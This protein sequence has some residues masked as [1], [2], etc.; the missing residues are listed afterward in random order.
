MVDMDMMREP[1]TP[2][3]FFKLGLMCWSGHGHALDRVAAHMWLNLAALKGNEEARTYRSELARE[4]SVDEMHEAQRQAR[5]WL[6][7]H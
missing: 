5:A 1:A 6:T 2:D 7:L 4:M 3:E